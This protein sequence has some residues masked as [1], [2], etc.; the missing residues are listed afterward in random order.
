MNY[1]LSKKKV[2][3]GDKGFIIG[4]RFVPISK[5]T[6]P[7]FYLPFDTD[8][9]EKIHEL[10]AT[11]TNTSYF[12]I[13]NDSQVGGYLRC[14]KPNQNKSKIYYEGS[15]NLFQY[16]TGDFTISYW[17]RGPDYGNQ[18]N[19][20]FS[21]KVEDSK[22]GFVIFRDLQPATMDFRLGGHGQYCSGIANE[23]KWNHWCWVFKSSVM[24]CYKNG[25]YSYNNVSHHNPE[26][27]GQSISN[28]ELFCI[29]Y[30]EIWNHKGAY[31]DLKALR[32]YKEAL[33]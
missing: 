30:C 2:E 4:D 28:Q 24:S 21:K 12:S 11:N 18:E 31:F 25:V 33:D 6:K 7:D 10:N 32:I 16:G 17:F 5:Q 23:N 29:G 9:N 8:I 14:T 1:I 15:Q 20:V 13:Q 26:F 3:V 22:P 27:S 19:V